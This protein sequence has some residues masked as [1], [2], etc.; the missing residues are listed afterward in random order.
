MLLVLAAF[1]F[2]VSTII[3]SRDVL[4]TSKRNMSAVEATQNARLTAHQMLLSEAKDMLRAINAEQNGLLTAPPMDA[5]LIEKEEADEEDYPVTTTVVRHT[6][7]PH[8]QAIGIRQI[9]LDTR[10]S[11]SKQA[12]GN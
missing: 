7:P 11:V 9:N 5:S 2:L 6:A 4:V 10:Q 12:P 1:L 8:V 3:Q